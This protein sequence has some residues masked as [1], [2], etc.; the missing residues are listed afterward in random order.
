MSREIIRKCRDLINSPE[1]FTFSQALTIHNTAFT[2]DY[3]FIQE[4]IKN[5]VRKIMQPKIEE[6]GYLPEMMEFFRDCPDIMYVGEIIKVFYREM[7]NI[8]RME[9]LNVDLGSEDFILNYQL[10][11][12]EMFIRCNSNYFPQE[13]Y[14]VA[15]FML[16]ISEN[17]IYS[18]R[19]RFSYM[20]VVGRL[21][22]RLSPANCNR[23]TAIFNRTRGQ[24]TNTNKKFSSVYN[25][26]QNVHDSSINRSVIENAK[27]L[28]EQVPQG[29]DYSISKF[30]TRIKRHI[31]IDK[32][33][34]INA[35]LNRI[36]NDVASFGAGITLQMVLIAVEYEI[37]HFIQYKEEAYSRL[38]EELYDAEKYCATGYLSRLV[39]SLSGYSKIVEIKISDYEQLKNVI[40]TMVEKEVG[41]SDEDLYSEM[42][43]DCYPNKFCDFLAKLI[44]EKYDHLIRE[45]SFEKKQIEFKGYII[46][47]L[48]HYT[49][50]NYEWTIN[51]FSGEKIIYVKTKL[52]EE[53]AVEIK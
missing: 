14:Q 1:N 4:I 48:T 49:G 26:S 9:G 23:Y 11:I 24:G 44:N 37:I 15:N 53:I 47:I 31:P 20:D 46:Q 51:P 21:Q 13:V 39:N 32:E 5:Q 3:R 43:N 34:V 28:V 6:K 36:R 17:I 7:N 2:S 25:D 29:Y 40:G 30:Y 22:S 18:E 8:P 41:K 16:D 50:K 42:L 35:A 27:K 10:G 52:K 33:P 12:L 19:V 38:I 45:Y